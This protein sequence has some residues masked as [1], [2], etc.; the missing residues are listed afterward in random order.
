MCCSTRLCEHGA[1]IVRRSRL[2]APKPSGYTVTNPHRKT[3]TI[4]SRAL[5]ADTRVVPYNLRRFRSPISCDSH[6]LK[7]ISTPPNHKKTFP[8]SPPLKQQ[9]KF[10]L[11][12]RRG[13]GESSRGDGGAWG[14]RGPCFQEGPLPPQGLT[15]PPR[16]FRLT[17][18]SA[19][20]G[21]FPQHTKIFRS[22]R[23]WDAVRPA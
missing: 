10:L 20:A 8:K 2:R 1:T 7:N 3:S 23:R 11:S 22:L 15:I 12:K 13:L 18:G 17:C 9:I 21:N 4:R 6:T 19:N 14:G 5:S 16:S